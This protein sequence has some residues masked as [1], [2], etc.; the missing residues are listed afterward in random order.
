M[1]FSTEKKDG[2]LVTHFILQGGQSAFS[3]VPSLKFAFEQQK[4]MPPSEG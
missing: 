3:V 1:N 4:K 2:L